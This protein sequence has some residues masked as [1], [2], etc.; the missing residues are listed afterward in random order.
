[1]IQI[2]IEMPKSCWGC[3]FAYYDSVYTLHCPFDDKGVDMYPDDRLDDCPLIE[4]ESE[5]FE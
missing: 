2:D 3:P 4:V 1:M 5:G